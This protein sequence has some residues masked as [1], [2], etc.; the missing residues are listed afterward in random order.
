MVGAERRRAEVPIIGQAVVGEAELRD[1]VRHAEVAEMLG[2]RLAHQRAVGILV[3]RLWP[4]EA[5]V[6]RN[7]R[8]RQ[9]V[10][11]VV[12]ERDHEL[13]VAFA[14]RFSSTPPG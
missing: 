10:A 1:E 12:I 8:T 6:A 13:V 4:G 14:S 3:D 7:R 5:R 2:H 9:E 11:P